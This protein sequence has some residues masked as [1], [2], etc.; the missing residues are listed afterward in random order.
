MT[1]DFKP[2]VIILTRKFESW[3]LSLVCC[4]CLYSM[5]L[6]HC[7]VGWSSVYDFGISGSYS[8]TFRT[9][10]IKMSSPPMTQSCQRDLRLYSF[11]SKDF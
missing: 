5:A 2:H 1:Y 9:H 10:G 6:P 11:M 7:A 4:D 8:L 3:L